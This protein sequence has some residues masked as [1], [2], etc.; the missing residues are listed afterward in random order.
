MCIT[1]C[2]VL[3]GLADRNNTAVTSSTI[4]SE[5]RKMR[6]RRWKLAG[7]FHSNASVELCDFAKRLYGRMFVNKAV[8]WNGL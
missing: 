3:F 4:L 8:I 6:K 2:K 5:E 1:L 7:H